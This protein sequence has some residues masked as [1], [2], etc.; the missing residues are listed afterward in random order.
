MPHFS[1]FWDSKKKQDFKLCS[2]DRGFIGAYQIELNRYRSKVIAI[3]NFLTATLIR[4]A[5]KK[6]A[7]TSDIFRMQEVNNNAN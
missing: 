7:K 5:S 2:S 6:Y 4:N 3:K 1:C